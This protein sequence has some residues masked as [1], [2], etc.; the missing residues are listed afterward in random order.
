MFSRASFS[1]SVL[2]R[3]KNIAELTKKSQFYSFTLYV[4]FNTKNVILIPSHLN[5]RFGC[6]TLILDILPKFTYTALK[7]FHLMDNYRLTTYKNHRNENTH[8]RVVLC[9][10]NG[11]RSFMLFEPKVAQSATN[12]RLSHLFLLHCFG[13]YMTIVREISNKGIQQW[14]IM[15]NMC[16][17]GVKNIKLN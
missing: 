11:L 14:R 15:L 7:I 2:F 4:W 13:L 6:S 12:K 16:M 10:T 1:E 17:F 8:V 9:L 3:E 5:F